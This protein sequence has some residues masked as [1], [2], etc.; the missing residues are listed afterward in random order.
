MDGG[1]DFSECRWPAPVA[2]CAADDRMNIH[3][4]H[5]CPGRTGISKGDGFPGSILHLSGIAGK[6]RRR[7]Q[8]GFEDLRAE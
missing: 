8:T 5:Q 3:E 4:R 2:G 1:A 7:C 6:S